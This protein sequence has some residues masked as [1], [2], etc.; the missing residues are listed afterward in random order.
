MWNR[1]KEFI[2]R[3]KIEVG[4]LLFV[5]VVATVSTFII[6]STKVLKLQS[7]EIYPQ[8]IYCTLSYKPSVNPAWIISSTT[9]IEIKNAEDMKSFKKQAYRSQ[10]IFKARPVA[11]TNPRHQHR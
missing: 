1:I 6:S 9:T 8:Y 5:S 7:G 2:K 10:F 3:R 4:I 11:P